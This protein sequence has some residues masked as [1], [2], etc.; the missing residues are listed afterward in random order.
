[1]GSSERIGIWIGHRK[2]MTRTMMINLTPWQIFTVIFLVFYW[3]L[4]NINSILVTVIISV[5][6]GGFMEV[7]SK[8]L[9]VWARE[10][11]V[12]ENW[13]SERS[14]TDEESDEELEEKYANIEVNLDD[15]ETEEEDYVPWSVKS[16]SRSVE[17]DS[18]NEERPLMQ[19]EYIL[20]KNEDEINECDFPDEFLLYENS[21]KGENISGSNR[22]KQ[23]FVE[24]DIDVNQ[25]MVSDIDMEDPAVLAAATKI[26]S[27]F[28]GFK[29][30]KNI[31]YQHGFK[32]D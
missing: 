26:Q 12:E 2:L 1:M 32:S 31:F 7:V 17:D 13:K 9:Y 29:T 24:A 23:I 19:S 15:S 8:Y 25:D 20:E 16:S 18:L 30:R 22:K 3:V 11:V 10:E 27:V 28:K 5:I 14:L 21:L 6:Y 4:K